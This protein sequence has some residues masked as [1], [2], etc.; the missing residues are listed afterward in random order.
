MTQDLHKQQNYHKPKKQ[1][2]HS[3]VDIYFLF[4][5]HKHENNRVSHKEAKYRIDSSNK[6]NRS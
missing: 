4:L 5:T 3:W 2:I 6:G 1:N